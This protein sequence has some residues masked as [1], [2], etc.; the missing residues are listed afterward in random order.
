MTIVVDPDWWQTLFD[1]VYLL[2]DAR[3]V[4]DPEVTRRETDLIAQVISPPADARILDL[5]GGQ[6]RHTLELCR[7]GCRDCTV[8]DYSGTLLA[9][10]RET[11]RQQDLPVR[12]VQADARRLP[13]GD[14]RFDSVLILGNSLGY[15][16]DARADLAIM[17][18]SHRVLAPSGTLLVDVT[19]ASY[20]RRKIAPVAWHEID[21]DVVVCREREVRENCVCA[22]EMVLSKKHGLIRDKNYR[23]R[24]YDAETLAG[25]L[26]RAGFRE[27]SQ[28]TQ[29]SGAV[30]GKRDVGC[31]QH[32]LFIS[33]RKT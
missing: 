31:M 27:I 22:R 18:E 12:F 20:V 6:G 23:I 32:R 26:D 11:A 15:L 28:H 9:I 5:C 8:V 3:T 30:D 4:G 25:L 21:A 14:E 2:T 17:I 16:P 1:E 24:L 29:P 19:D 7:R 10:G 13:L 33:A